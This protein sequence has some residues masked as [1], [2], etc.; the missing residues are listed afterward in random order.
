MKTIIK[1]NWKYVIERATETPYGQKYNLSIYENNNGTWIL[2]N[3]D[4]GIFKE[5]IQLDYGITF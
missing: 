1:N 2:L 4:N 3:K 5:D